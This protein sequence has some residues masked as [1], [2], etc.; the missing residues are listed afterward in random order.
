MKLGV[1]ERMILL[2]L[3]AMVDDYGCME[4]SPRIVRSSVFSETGIHLWRIVWGM[5]KLAKF[6][7]VKLHKTNCAMTVLYAKYIVEMLPRYSK[8]KPNLPLPP[9][10]D[11][12]DENT[13]S[14]RIVHFN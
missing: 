5:R 2:T 7:F 11:W 4:Y 1:V 12:Y 6:G 8:S 3:P 14:F 10:V 9:Q 13:G